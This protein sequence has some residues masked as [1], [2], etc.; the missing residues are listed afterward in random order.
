MCNS[1]EKKISLTLSFMIFKWKNTNDLSD[2]LYFLF[3]HKDFAQ[4]A[5]K[6]LILIWNDRRINSYARI[7]RLNATHLSL[8]FR[9]GKI[10][11]IDAQLGHH[12]E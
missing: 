12:F 4:N 3:K 1:L 9:V 7:S 5:I 6:N 2:V 8:E 11:K 10:K